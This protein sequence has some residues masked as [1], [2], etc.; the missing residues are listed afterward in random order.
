MRAAWGAG[1]CM[2]HA[3]EDAQTLREAWGKEGPGDGG[4]P[5]EEGPG[6]LP[7]LSCLILA[8]YLCITLVTDS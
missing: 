5:G 8:T 6:A 4:L 7:A 2:V 1:V 3:H